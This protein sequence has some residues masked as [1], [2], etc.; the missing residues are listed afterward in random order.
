VEV[1]AGQASD[2]AA[3]PLR[4]LATELRVEAEGD[5]VALDPVEHRFTH[6]RA[7]YLPWAIPARPASASAESGAALSED[8]VWAT[9]ARAD[10]L[11]LPVAQRRV[12]EAWRRSCIV[13][14]W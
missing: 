13:E 12:L 6:L 1:V 8:R 11:A 5:G 10:D 2:A 9:P 4:A 3:S 7:I 14:G